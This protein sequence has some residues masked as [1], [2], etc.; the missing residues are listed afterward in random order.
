M[1]LPVG[2]KYAQFLETGVLRILNIA[3]PHAEQEGL[4]LTGLAPRGDFLSSGWFRRYIL[5]T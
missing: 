4:L 5:L 3:Q 2:V 1:T